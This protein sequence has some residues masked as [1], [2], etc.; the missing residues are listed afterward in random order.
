MPLVT[1]CSTDET[2]TQ[3]SETKSTIKFGIAADITGEFGPWWPDTQDVIDIAI[4][5]INADPPLGH[6]LE[7]V[8]S[9]TET[10]PEGAIKT[11][12][13]LG[14]QGVCF[15]I[16]YSSYELLA[17]LDTIGRFGTPTFAQWAGSISLDA[18]PQ[19]KDRLFFR[20]TP[21]DSSRGW[22]YGIYWEKELA[23]Q[24]Y[25]TIAVLSATDEASKSF[26]MRGQ[27]G[28]EK[29]GAD[30]VYYTSFPPEQTTFARVLA[31][32]FAAEPDVIFLGTSVTQG[33][34]VMKEWWDSGFSKDILWMVPDEWAFPEGLETVL[35]APGVLDNKVVAVGEVQQFVSKAY[36]IMYSAYEDEYGEG[37]VPGHT[38]GFNFWDALNIASLAI[39]AA[40]EATPE[41]VSE[42]S[43]VVANPPGVEVHSYAEGKKA[44]DEGKEINYQGAASPDDFDEYGNVLGSLTIMMVIDNQWLEIKVYTAE[45]QAEFE[46]K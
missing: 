19:G 34:I 9:D 3:T 13:Y 24:G 5:T 46:S 41:A 43:V 23:P 40:G 16:G 33:K 38:Y 8:V 30:V 10:T 35:P 28:L 7:A 29:A 22:V 39:V 4:E 14:G 1:A 25:K 31:D 27:T 17:A 36:E 20:T 45:E 37:S 21:S 44:L 32:T 26:T 11:A 42:Y 12:S 2:S 15:A 6:P 18:T